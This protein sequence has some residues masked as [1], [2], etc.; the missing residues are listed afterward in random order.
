M[1]FVFFIRVLIAVNRKVQSLVL[2]IFTLTVINTIITAG[3]FVFWLTFEKT[4]TLI[5]FSKWKLYQQYTH[6]LSAF[7]SCLGSTFWL[8]CMLI[9][10]FSHVQLIAT[11][12]TIARQGPL[13][14][15]FPRQE[16]W[17][18]LP[19]PPLGDLPDPGIKP[20]SLNVSCIGIWV[21]YY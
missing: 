15:G 10:H 16:Y 17:S 9:S 12:W 7:Q 1:W 2:F 4:E 19:C 8:A 13:S 18:G 5:Y 3:H 11:P 20:A 14:V 6:Y 21:L